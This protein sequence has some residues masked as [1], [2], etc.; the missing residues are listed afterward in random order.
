MPDI[1]SRYVSHNVERVVNNR[2]TC[3]AFVI[4]Q[5][6]RIRQWFIATESIQ[7]NKVSSVGSMTVTTQEVHLLDSNDLV[8][9][10]I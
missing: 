10:N 7:I 8:T 1:D 3:Q 4:H 9:T 5:S 6:E 2:Y